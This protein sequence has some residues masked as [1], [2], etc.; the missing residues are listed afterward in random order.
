MTSQIVMTLPPAWAEEMARRLPETA[1]TATTFS[2]LFKSAR[3]SLKVMAPYVDPTISALVAGANARVK[4]LTTPCP[5]RPPRPNP[6]LER[7]AAT[8]GHEVR[9][10][11]ERRDR[12]LV[13]QTHAKAVIADGRRAWLGS[14]NLTDT[15]LH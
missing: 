10:L 8:C 7:T 3:R 12:A 2:V 9:Y 6:V 11:N 5:G 4:I 1:S 15:S 14:A 13:F